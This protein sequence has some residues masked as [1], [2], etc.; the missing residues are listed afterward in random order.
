[1]DSLSSFLKTALY[2]VIFVLIVGVPAVEVLSFA[3]FGNG[4]LLNVVNS[5]N[6]TP[7]N[8]TCINTE[9]HLKLKDVRFKNSSHSHEYPPGQLYIS[10][11]SVKE[12]NI[13]IRNASIKVY[14]DSILKIENLNL[15]KVKL[16]KERKLLLCFRDFPTA[17][18]LF[19]LLLAFII[20]EMLCFVGES[21]IGVFMFGWNPFS[22]DKE[23][24]LVTPCNGKK[25]DI[26]HIRN[27]ANINSVFE[28]SEIH[29]VMSRVFA[30]LGIV[31]LMVF[32][33]AKKSWS[34]WPMVLVFIFVIICFAISKTS[35]EE[36]C[37]GN[38]CKKVK[39][40]A[41]KALFKC[42][43][44]CRLLLIIVILWLSLLL[45][46]QRHELLGSFSIFLTFLISVVY[47]S[48]ANRLLIHNKDD[49]K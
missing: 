15:L 37:C 23:L 43:P 13:F 40:V 31:L 36:T 41:E 48:H 21:I 22:S 25:P 30:G 4:M 42:P 44:C 18:W 12:M 20:G 9:L 26:S 6:S 16:N 3:V 11:N 24:E 28:M 45:L 49:K 27:A 2:R 39:D 34:E 38:I 46:L 5:V 14:E 1:M 17:G 7:A 33:T 32:L 35:N 10:P 19:Y 47:R 29:Y 8:S